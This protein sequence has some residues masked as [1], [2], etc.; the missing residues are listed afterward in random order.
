MKIKCCLDYIPY[1][2]YV[3]CLLAVLISLLI[4]CYM[5]K[6][7][8]VKYKVDTYLKYN[9]EDLKESEKSFK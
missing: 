1:L 7:D 8:A 9:R 3:M 4:I 5:E 6:I 2:S